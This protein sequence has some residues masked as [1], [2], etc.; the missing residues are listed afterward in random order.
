MNLPHL[1]MLLAVVLVYLP[2]FFTAKGQAE[3][4]EGYDN[5]NPRDQQAKLEGLARRAV[6]AHQNGF[7]AIATFL[8]AVL[9]AELAGA[10]A[11]VVGQLA[12]LHVAARAVYVALYLA[13]RHVLRSVVWTVGFVATIG[14]YVQALHAT[15]G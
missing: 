5:A 8:P 9:A 13:N 1:C 10:D 4:A 7:E 14:L 3:R 2:R 11:T 6:A 15:P 12:M